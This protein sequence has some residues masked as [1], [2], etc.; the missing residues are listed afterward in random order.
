MLDEKLFVI[1]LKKLGY[2]FKMSTTRG[3]RG[4]R[5]GRGRGNNN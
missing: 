4:G 1:I 2:K 5:G 3:G